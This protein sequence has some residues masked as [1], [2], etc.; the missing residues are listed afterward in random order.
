VA[1]HSHRF[2]DGFLWGASTSAFQIEGAVREAGRLPSIWDTFSRIPGNILNDDTADVA[3]DHYHRMDTDVGLMVDLGL[4]AYRFSVAWPRIIP[5]GSGPVNRSGIDF[6]SRLVDRLLQAGIRPFL[7]LYHWDLPQP[8]QD[9]GGWTTRDTAWRFAEYAAVVA[10]ELGDR[11]DTWTTL[12]EPWCSSMFGYGD[13]SHAPGIA[14]RNAAFTAA[15]HLLLAHGLG[16]ESLRGSLPPSATVG[17]TLNLAPFRGRTDRAEDATAVRHADGTMNR[18]FLDPLFRGEYPPDIVADT[19]PTIDWG[20]VEDGD[21]EVIGAPID[22]LGI[23]YYMPVTV[24]GDPG[25][26]PGSSPWPGTTLA[27]PQPMADL[28]HTAMGWAIEPSGLS[29]VLTRISREF[30]R[31]PLYVTENGAAFEDVVGPSGA[32]DDVER[33]DYLRGH[34]QAAGDAI[35]SGVDLRGYFVW[36]LMDNFEWSLG[37]APRFGLVAVHAQTLERTPKASADWYRDVILANGLES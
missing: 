23:N 1:E 33:I 25:A 22:F 14:D 4:Q 10:T 35:A 24:S 3:T 26:S 36:T 21:L 17:I 18:L 11:V 16:V 8:L 5:T 30:T 6:Y 27:F 15:H 32:I 13:G 34:I 29:E 12:N 31:I 7:T 28:P 20:F 37:Y 2:P 19:R 9:R